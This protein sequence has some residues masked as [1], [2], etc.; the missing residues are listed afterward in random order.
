MARPETV[1]LDPARE[2]VATAAD[3]AGA[4][5]PP[6]GQPSRAEIV[7]RSPGRLDVRAQGPGVLVLAD[8]W[9]PGW[10]ARVDERPAR[11][12]RVNHAELAVAVP[13]GTHRVLLRY[14]P[15]A[16]GA[17]LALCALGAA[18]LAAAAA[19]GRRAV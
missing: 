12:L 2:V 1:G 9:D 14:R 8:S 10:S 16:L 4:E 6:S 15:R 5:L 11:V 7:R 18:V 17:G 3:L 13:A 19:R